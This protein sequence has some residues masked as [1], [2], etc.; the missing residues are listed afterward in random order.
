MT[1]GPVDPQ[2]DLV[3]LEH[4]VQAR[5]QAHD[6]LD[7]VAQLRTGASPWVFYEGP[8]TANARPGLHHVWPRAFKDLF[9]RFQT[10]RGHAVPRKGGWDC[11][12]LPVEIE[13][14]KELGISNKHEIEAFGIA[15][16]NERCRASVR[17]YVS[18]FESLTERA[19]VWIDTHDA[20]WTLDNSY[21]E[22]VWWLLGRLWAD[23]LLYEGFRVSPYCARCGT[24][25][26]SHE[27]G[28][29]G[30]YRDVTDPS[31]YVRF[32]VPDRDFDLLVWTTTPWTLISN[33]A[34][35]V[36]PDIDYVRVRSDGG[37]DLVLAAARAPHD[38]EVVSR[39]RGT[40]LV[41]L[42][43][44]RPF[45]LLPIDDRGQ[46]VVAADFVSTDE[47]T[48]IV[49]LA[50]AFGADD[51]DVA[52]REGLPVL[53]P[54]GP[55]GTFG[56]TVPPW[57]GRFVKDADTDII[58]DLAHR[59]LLVRQEPHLHSYPHCWRCGTPLLYWAKTSW[60]VRT[61]ER[62]T[63]LLRENERIGWHPEY[64][65]HG[66]FGDWL[67]NNVDWA[68]S[69]DRYWGTPLPVWR[70]T[71][72]HDT[73][74]S[75]LAQ[76]RE[77]SGRDLADLDLHRPYVDE[78]VLTCPAEGC[79]AEARRLPPVI[80]AWF[81]SGSMPT[82]Q[83]H[84]K[85]D[86]DEPV[87]FPSDFI[88]EAID[89]TRGWFYSLL[90]VNTLV[91]GSTPYRNVVCL[92]LIVDQDGQ[93]MSKSRGNV[94]DPWDVFESLGADALR[95][96]FF[97][98]GSP[99]SSRRVYEDGIREATRK[100]LL[101]FW[102]V[103]SFFATYADIEGWTP[104][105]EPTPPAHVL[106]RWI[107]GRL[108]ETVLGATDA[109]D[110]FDALTAAT[111]TAR[112]IDDLS[113]WY[114][115]R[116]R[117]RFW[118]ASDAAAYTTLYRCLVEGAQLLAPF[119]P[120]IADD[121]YVGLTGELSVHA[122]DWPAAPG[123]PDTRLGEEMAAA[124]QLVGLG[125]A[126]RTDAKIRTRQPLKRALLVHP[127][128]VELGPDVRAEIREELNVK[129]LQ[130]VASLAELVSWTVVPNFR[131]LG[132]RLGS[133]VNEVKRALGAADGAALKASLDEHGWV[134]VAGER[135]TAEDVELRASQHE[136]FALASE[137]AWAVALDL[138]VDDALRVEGTAREL[139]R[140]L[141]QA[142]KDAGLAITD[143]VQITS[144]VA[145]APRVDAALQ[146]HHEWIAG[147]VLAVT[148]ERG[149]V[150]D[151]FAAEIDGEP[152]RVAIAPA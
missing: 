124:R 54:V 130:D 57:E 1:Y 98:A 125:R 81:D 143:R 23:G 71:Q 4:R 123:E 32:P 8:P 47:G 37:R 151:G 53:N 116:S 51:M 82:A 106:D 69:R 12:G 72:G 121:V 34:A 100:T 144:D 16:F 103:F 27:L 127:R 59:G 50:P 140:A 126:A 105:S 93:K 147:E 3:E 46:R 136:D 142:R 26:S 92:G 29:P 141:N 43:Y 68:L 5:W 10:M 149:S 19:A 122:S 91:F 73:C 41:D 111:E 28:Q 139:V 61:A 115:R 86:T 64:I 42:R 70:C 95:W 113:N 6:V 44:R 58:D 96:Y 119:T 146:A 40:E 99:W 110:H 38:A 63:D 49:H 109:L 94:I 55:D 20:Y 152:V 15:A 13:V 24:A 104:P 60:F 150:D 97:S 18:D 83:H 76:L 33:V 132:P 145:Q 79:G 90:A 9:I 101:T 45:E 88:C 129:E 74:V 85:G 131:T 133:R 148:L 89:Q 65:K 108:D 56:A 21:I 117:P 107:L 112:F 134:E 77:L 114:V 78:V 135:L 2:L 48:G 75:S 31:V 118:A 62:R 128:T 52:Q 36:G 137:G 22:S 87:D 7:T 84:Y 66:R 67:E 30:A 17:R 25:L 11:H 120:Y 102:N 14:E 39:M 35:A 80:D 138:E